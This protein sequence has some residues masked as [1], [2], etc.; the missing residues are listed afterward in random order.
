MRSPT[1]P[2]PPQAPHLRASLPL[3]RFL[4]WE[5]G[6]CSAQAVR[7][8]RRREFAG[9]PAFAASAGHIEIP[10][11]NSPATFAASQFRHD[12]A[13]AAEWRNLVK[14]LLLLRHQ[15][16]VPYLSSAKAAG[17]HVLGP[18]SIFAS[19]QLANGTALVLATNLSD[20]SVHAD[21]PSMQPLYG[22]P[23][24]G[25]KLPPFTTLAWILP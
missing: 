21:F 24:S 14:T 9:D 13:A 6:F 8:G 25:Q 5:T 11:P 18:K 23:V 10:D 16:I 15:H 1:D 12:G 3:W 4:S 17:A 22:D 2:V 20:R 7:D 19:W